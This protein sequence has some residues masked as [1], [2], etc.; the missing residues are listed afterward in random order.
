MVIDLRARMGRSEI[1]PPSRLIIT[2]GTVKD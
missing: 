2:D 1:I